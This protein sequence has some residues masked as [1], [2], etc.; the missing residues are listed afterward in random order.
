MTDLVE[1]F[2]SKVDVGDALE[3]WMWKAGR[4]RGLMLSKIK[5][6]ILDE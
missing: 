2:W 1:R 3:C 5:E 4:V 6:E